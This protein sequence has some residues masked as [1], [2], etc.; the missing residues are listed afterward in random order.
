MPFKEY[1]IALQPS[2]D[3]IGVD[4]PG[5]PTIPQEVRSAT[6]LRKIMTTK[7]HQEHHANTPKK[8][9]GAKNVPW[10]EEWEQTEAA[11][12]ASAV[13]LQSPPVDRIRAAATDFVNDR[14]WPTTSAAE[15]GPRFIFERFLLYI[16]VR[17][18]EAGEGEDFYDTEADD[19]TDNK[20]AA[21]NPQEDDLA[22]GIQGRMETTSE[23]ENSMTFFN[24]PE[25]AIKIFLSSYARQM[26]FIW[27]DLNL[28]CVARTLEF[29]VNFLL[30]SD[31]LPDYDHSLYRSLEVIN[32]AKKELPD[33]SSIAKA[34]PDVF[35]RACG[36]CWGWKAEGYQVSTIDEAMTCDEADSKGEGLVEEQNQTG[37]HSGCRNRS[38]CKRGSQLEWEW[39]GQFEWGA[40]ARD[41]SWSRTADDRNV[42]EEPVVPESIPECARVDVTKQQGLIQLLGPTVLP[43]THTTG[44]VEKSIRCIK[45]IIPPLTNPARHPPQPEGFYE[46]NAAAVESDFDRNFVKLIL[47]PMPVDWDSGEVLAYSKPEVLAT[48]QGS[49]TAMANQSATIAASRS[50]NPLQDEIQL[51]IEP[52]PE[53]VGLLSVG[54]G[55]GGTWVEIIRVEDLVKELEQGKS[56]NK[57]APSYW[58][59]D[60]LSVV[61]PSFWTIKS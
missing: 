8:S 18:N 39:A 19:D 11:R 21:I 35:S 51:L 31:V 47:E 58:Y 59:L 2:S 15:S 3:G 41:S 57:A 23:E 43:L 55:L 6:D 33:T 45:A 5:V 17:V 10:Y 4:F 56:N 25:K 32:L 42:C 12:L 48:S 14:K 38:E 1:N 50:H 13:N 53:I 27:C 40:S 26:G 52:D 54:I 22:R 24:D 16:G 49:A 28:D 29:F 60:T 9:R 7:E 30:R 37:T 20:D 34:F 44:I 46:P 61:I 36:I